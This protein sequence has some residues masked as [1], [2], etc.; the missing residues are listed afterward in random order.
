VGTAAGAFAHD[1][2]GSAG[3]AGGPRP[4]KVVV[5][6]E[7]DRLSRDAQAALRRTMEK[8]M[9]QCRLILCCESVSRVIA[10]LRSRCLPVRVAAPTIVQICSVLR[11]VA[12]MERLTLPDEFAVRV[13][14]DSG[15]NLRK[16]I[17]MLE[18]CKVE[19]YP[20]KE[21]Q[22]PRKADWERF[23]EALAVTIVEQQSPQQLQLARDKLYELLTN[24]IP[25]DIILKTLV[26]CLLRRTDD[27]LRHQIAK[28]AAHYEHRMSCGTKPIF[29][30][31]AFIA[32]FM[33]MYK[34]WIAEFM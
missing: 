10:P 18:A 34:R 16:A 33:A 21:Q 3:G 1:S 14:T 19:H 22:I 7:V 13:A 29:H 30:L 9:T 20:F 24:C 11:N 17:L 27:T 4:F 25:P 26:S 23:I 32:K 28:W 12:R 5:L 31:E 6:N 15:R 8:Y 2:K